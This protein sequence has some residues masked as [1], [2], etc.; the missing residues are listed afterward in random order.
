MQLVQKGI[1]ALPELRKR[2]LMPTI[3]FSLLKYQHLLRLTL[4]VSQNIA[5]QQAVGDVFTAQYRL[6]QHRVGS[7]GNTAFGKHGANS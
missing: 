7:Q 3:G 6:G 4:R 2:L 1:G 5:S